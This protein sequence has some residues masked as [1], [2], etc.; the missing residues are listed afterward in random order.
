MKHLTLA[1]VGLAATAFAS[2]AFAQSST[3]QFI[4]D[5]E[6]RAQFDTLSEY[7]FRGQSRGAQSLVS[8]TETKLPFGLSGGVLYIAGV[9]P[10]SDV[11]RDEIRV[12][13]NYSVPVGDAVSVDVGGTH[14]YYPQFGGLF[15]TRGGSAGSYEAYGSVGLDEVFLNPKAKVY[16]DFTLEN[17]TIEGSLD[18]SFDLP[19]ENWSANIGVTGGYVEEDSSFVASD[20]PLD[21]GWV[22]ASI[23]LDKVITDNIAFFVDGNFTYNTEDD[24]LNFDRQVLGTG[25]AVAFRDSSTKFWFGTGIVLN[26]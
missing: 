20:T 22:T 1:A 11:Q 3:S 15:E 10:D 21:Y 2:P 7:V 5:I 8:D 17:L 19:R 9:D 16:Y 12:Y 25:D 18:H 6:V 26:F 4:E 24:T 23:G 14:Y 13:A